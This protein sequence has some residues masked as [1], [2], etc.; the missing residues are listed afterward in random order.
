VSEVSTTVSA[1]GA[2]AGAV[3]TTGIGVARAVRAS[4]MALITLIWDPDLVT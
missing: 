1:V 4:S 3:A 2:A